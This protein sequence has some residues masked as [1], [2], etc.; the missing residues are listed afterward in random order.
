MALNIGAAPVGD[1]GSY[2][3][4]PVD[5][6]SRQ[7]DAPARP[8]RWITSTFSGFTPEDHAGVKGG[9]MLTLVKGKPTIMPEWIDK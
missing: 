9:F 7:A 3:A 8:P 1:F 5:P 6:R 2:H 4:E